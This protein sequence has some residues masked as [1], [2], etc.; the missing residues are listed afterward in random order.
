[1]TAFFIVLLLS[2]GSW[3][4]AQTWSLE[5]NGQVGANLPIHPNY[6]PLRPGT[7]AAEIGWL[8]HTQGKTLW[9]R[10]HGR[11][12]VALLL[13]Y[14]ALG[15]ATVLGD[16]WHL[17]PCL[18]F[19]LVEQG[20][21]GLQARVGWGVAWLTKPYHSTFNPTNIA[22][23][24]HLNAAATLRLL[25]AYR[26]AEHWSAVAGVGATHYS[27][28]RLSLPNL[29]ANL[30]FG[31]VGL[32]YHFGEPR[33]RVDTA[34]SS[35]PK[36]PPTWRRFRPYALLGLG[37][38]E[39]GTSQGPKYPFYQA[40]LGISRRLATTSLLSL[41]AQYA[42]HTGTAAFDRHNG[43]V[44]Y[45]HLNY[46]RLS[47]VATHE[48]LFGHWGFVTGLGVYLNAHRFQRSL[49]LGR[50]GFNL[51]LKNYLKQDRHQCWLGVYVRTYS[52]EAE[53]VELALGY[54]W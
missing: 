30:P 14:Q 7:P 37:W 13:G 1:M 20:R 9:S 33:A 29:G 26:V 31:T 19:K 2:W 11:P 17:L 44:P 6:P 28:G 40:E 34:A 38:T 12:T 5:L 46:A 18:D 3:A 35:R 47:V 21:F 32:R 10:L 53:L 36:L 51:Y 52:G 50:I 42:Y 49:L 4:S 16:A 15:N 23:G 48:L 45:A 39:V 25:A 24:T 27:N 54:R 41:S 43:A 8:H 22:I